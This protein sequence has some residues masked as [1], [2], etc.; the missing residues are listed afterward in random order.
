VEDKLR[1][2]LPEKNS[3][4]RR[5]KQKEEVKRKFSRNKTGESSKDEKRQ[6]RKEDVMSTHAYVLVDSVGPPSAE[7]CRAAASFP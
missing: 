1:G 2:N 3:T 7:V 4:H 5:E 6:Q